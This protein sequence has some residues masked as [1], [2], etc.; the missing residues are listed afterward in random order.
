LGG[1]EIALTL[2][3]LYL[4]RDGVFWVLEGC[5][6]MSAVAERRAAEGI[7]KVEKEH[8]EQMGVMRVQWAERE[9]KAQER[10][11]G[12]VKAANQVSAHTPH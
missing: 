2:L 3:K 11:T 4:K 1:A 6:M 9:A 7:V 8:E 10:E 12:Q 5:W